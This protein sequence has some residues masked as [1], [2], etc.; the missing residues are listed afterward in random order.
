VVISEFDLIQRYFTSVSLTNSVN[1]LGVG[2][3]CALMSI[4]EGYELALTVDTMVEG[5]HFFAGAD[6]GAVQGDERGFSGRFLHF[7]RTGRVV[8]AWYSQG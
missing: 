7:C 5:V 3:D 6:P 8:P 1:Q 2:D 4:P